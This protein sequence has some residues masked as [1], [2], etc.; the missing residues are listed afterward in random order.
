MRAV[1][2]QVERAGSSPRREIERR[3]ARI[4]SLRK[5]NCLRGLMLGCGFYGSFQVGGYA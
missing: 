1:V 2:H 3:V 4:G 5:Y